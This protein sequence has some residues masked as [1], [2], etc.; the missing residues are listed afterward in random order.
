MSHT[1]LPLYLF[2][3]YFCVS[4][5]VTLFSLVLFAT[6]FLEDNYLL[7]PALTRNSGFYRRIA[8]DLR[9]GA[10]TDDERRDLYLGP[11]FSF[12]RRNPQGLAVFDRELLSACFNDCVTHLDSPPSLRASLR[13]VAEKVKLYG[14]AGG[15]SN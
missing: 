14:F 3:L 5:A 13:Q 6:L 2:D 8:A 12:D 9:I 11:L 1:A 4:L 15:R 10:A 7:A